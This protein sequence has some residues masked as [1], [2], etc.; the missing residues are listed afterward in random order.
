MKFYVG[1]KSCYSELAWDKIVHES[2]FVFVLL[3]LFTA[4]PLLDVKEL[5]TISRISL[6]KGKTLT[7]VSTLGR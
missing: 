2:P 7:A 5:H 3:P 1:N 6:A 4:P